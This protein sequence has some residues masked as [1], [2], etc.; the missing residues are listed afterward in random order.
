MVIVMESDTKQMLKHILV[1]ASI[2]SG[3]KTICGNDGGAAQ[4]RFVCSMPMDEVLDENTFFRLN[5]RDRI[6]GRESYVL[7]NKVLVVS[8]ARETECTV[9]LNG[10]HKHKPIGCGEIGGP[11]FSLSGSTLEKYEE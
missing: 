10:S 1:A 2:K 7:G 4:G 9:L 5:L 6:H 11:V 8:Q 3:T